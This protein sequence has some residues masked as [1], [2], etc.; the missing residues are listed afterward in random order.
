MGAVPAFRLGLPVPDEQ[1]LELGDPIEV[2]P[3]SVRVRPDSLRRGWPVGRLVGMS[4][5]GIVVRFEET[6]R[7]ERFAWAERGLG[8]RRARS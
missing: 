6:G 1:P 8:W 7:T 4:A 3:V 2:A 5:E